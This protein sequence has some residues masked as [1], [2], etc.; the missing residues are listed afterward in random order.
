MTCASKLIDFSKV[1]LMGFL[2]IHCILEV[3]DSRLFG[4]F[5]EHGRLLGMD[6]QAGWEHV[7]TPSGDDSRS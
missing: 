5:L 4:P 6:V 7:E 3:N 1:F 2:G